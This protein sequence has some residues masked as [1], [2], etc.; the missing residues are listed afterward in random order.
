MEEVRLWSIG[1]SRAFEDRM[2]AGCKLL[3]LDDGG[4]LRESTVTG[5]PSPIGDIE[6]GRPY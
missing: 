6:D 1:T 4:T 2:A 3:S 5:D